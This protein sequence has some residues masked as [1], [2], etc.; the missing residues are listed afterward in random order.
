MDRD[1]SSAA[2]QYFNKQTNK[3]RGFTVSSSSNIQFL[4]LFPVPAC[5]MLGRK[6]KPQ[7]EISSKPASN[8]YINSLILNLLSQQESAMAIAP[9][10]SDIK[11]NM[12]IGNPPFSGTAF[13][14]KPRFGKT[15][16]AKCYSDKWDMVIVDEE[17]Y[18][19]VNK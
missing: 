17:Y 11:A 6:L 5:Q 7:L 15:L 19:T 10:S 12:I 3:G 13:H 9:L 14:S 2:E 1:W 8:L 16:T 4:P 18:Q